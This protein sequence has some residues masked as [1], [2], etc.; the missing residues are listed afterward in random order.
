MG[1]L[2]LS[3]IMV[4]VASFAQATATVAESSRSVASAE[5]GDVV[6]LRIWRE[7][8]MSGD[9]PVDAKGIAT[10]PRVGTINVTRFGADSL[11]RL[12][13][14]EYAKYL[15]NPSV[16]IVLLRRVRVVG[17]VKSPGVYT[18]DQTMRVRDVLALAGGASAEGRTDRARL[19][20]DGTSTEIDLSTSPRADEVALRSGD[21][22]SVPQ[23]SWFARNTPL[24][25]AIISVSGGLL[26]ALVAR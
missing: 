24:V 22:L 3:A 10:F 2:T 21:Q 12:L 9:Y 8:D 19:D 14:A 18:V 11:Q 23:R 6:R 15:K 17:A 1:L 4:P 13:V 20:R 26:F 16:E 7:P 25:A 5:P